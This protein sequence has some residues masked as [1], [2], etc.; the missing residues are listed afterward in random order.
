MNEIIEKIK[1]YN[2][3]VIFRHQSPDYD[4]FGSSFG[5]YEILKATYPNKKI[6]LAGEFTSDLIEKFD[7]NLDTSL[8]YDSNTLGIVLDTAN[9][10]RIDG[11]YSKCKEFI[12]IDHHPIVENYADIQI[13]DDTASSTC[14]L[15]THFYNDYKDELKITLSAANNLYMGIIGDSSR[16]LFKSTDA[17]T[18]KAAGILVDL[19]VDI[20]TIYNKMY[21]SNEKDMLIKKHILNAYRVNGHVAYYVLEDK[22]LKELDIPRERGSDFVNMLSQ[23]KEYYVWVAVT[24]NT[25]D[26]NYRVSIRSRDYC[27]NKVANKY[28][29][30]GHALASGCRLD[31]IDQLPNL[32]KDLNDLF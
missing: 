11:E 8:K 21:L 3:I 32:L 15:V 22:D 10:D 29:G 20:T 14:Q 23:V 6:Y 17:R 1:S 30:G 7:I 27:V 2:N 16:F 4:A 13:V 31:S 28:N 25:V 5:F 19:G 12:K 9:S 18:F 24:Q 26:N